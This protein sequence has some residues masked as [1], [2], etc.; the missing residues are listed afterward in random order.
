LII[1]GN[2]EEYNMLASVPFNLPLSVEPFRWTGVSSIIG[3]SRSVS[4]GIL[5]SDRAKEETS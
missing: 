4:P 2:V 1:E 5:S 3:K